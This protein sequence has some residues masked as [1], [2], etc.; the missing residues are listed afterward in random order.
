[1]ERVGPM[2]TGA[3]RRH[4]VL[5]GL[6]G[7]GKSTVGPL[8]A[9]ALD[10]HFTDLDLVISHATGLSIVELF[11]EEGESAFRLRERQALLDALL[12]PPHVV[13]PGGGWAAQPGNLT[14]AGDRITTVYLRLA[15]DLAAERLAGAN[16]R[17]LL[18]GNND[19]TAGLRLLLVA[20]EGFYRASDATV[21]AAGDPATVAER[22]VTAARA[23]GW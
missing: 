12:L 23:T 3:V 5:I 19:L 1:M 9:H 15:P 6:P 16:D 10:T 4:L 22:V 13:A 2:T 8:V 7:S 11:A 14:Q 21:D 20:R 17:P 18:A